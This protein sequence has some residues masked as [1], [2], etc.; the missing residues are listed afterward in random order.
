MRRSAPRRAESVSFWLEAELLVRLA[1]RQLMKRK[2]TSYG[3][4][5][6]DRSGIGPIWVMGA[7]TA[8]RAPRFGMT[9]R[10]LHARGD[11]TRNL[12]RAK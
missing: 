1:L 2:P 6:E 4:R 3:Y 5:R 9:P 7:F 10:E 8:I 12:L 11:V